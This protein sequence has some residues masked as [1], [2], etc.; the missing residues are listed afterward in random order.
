MVASQHEQLLRSVAE[1]TLSL[2][3]FGTW[4]WGDTIAIDGLLEAGQVVGGS[5][6]RT[7]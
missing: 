4:Y 7:S 5:Y 2:F 6:G 1:R 3:R